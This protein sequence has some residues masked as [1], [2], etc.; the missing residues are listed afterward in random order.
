MIWHIVLSATNNYPRMRF[1]F[2]LKTYSKHPFRMILIIKTSII[3]PFPT[4]NGVTSCIPCSG[5]GGL[6]KESC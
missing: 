5:G 3:A 4:N 2:R 1:E 6:S